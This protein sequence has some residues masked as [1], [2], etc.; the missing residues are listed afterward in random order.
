M[1][2]Q[3][4]TDLGT[5]LPVA[6]ALLEDIGETD[7]E[8]I[9]K[10]PEDIE[11]DPARIK[12]VEIEVD[13]TTKL[14]RE[15]RYNDED[16][17][18]NDKRGVRFQF[19]GQSDVEYYIEIIYFP[20]LRGLTQ[21]VLQQGSKE[22]YVGNIYVGTYCMQ[23][24]NDKGSTATLVYDE[25]NT[26]FIKGPQTIFEASLWNAFGPTFVQGEWKRVDETIAEYVRKRRKS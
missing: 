24:T 14:F 19:P 17:S 12:E 5:L 6:R 16:G 18:F 25:V 23:C 13:E 7:L 15:I 4:D 8:T 1:L 22:R 11:A 20:R 21:R 2:K 9:V 26:R 3:L 10:E